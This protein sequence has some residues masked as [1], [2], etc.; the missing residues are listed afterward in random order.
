ML[1]WIGI[2]MGLVVI[3]WASVWMLI[4]VWRELT[5]EDTEDEICTFCGTYPPCFHIDAESREIQ[6]CQVH[7]AP[8]CPKHQT[9]RH[10]MMRAEAKGN[11]SRCRFQTN[12]LVATQEETDTYTM[13]CG[14]N[15]GHVGCMAE[16]DTE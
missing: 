10:C 11:P 2:G 1:L 13:V 3:G 15:C 6:W 8:K 4:E 5:Q 12:V 9:E 7:D 16:E 14:V